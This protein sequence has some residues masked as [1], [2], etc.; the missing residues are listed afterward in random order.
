MFGMEATVIAWG[1]QKGGIGKTTS[2][3]AMS[4]LLAKKG[5]RVLVIDFDPQGSQIQVLT[6]QNKAD[7]EGFNIMMA[8]E[9]NNPHEHIVELTKE[10][11]IIPSDR[12]LAN[13]EAWLNKN[14]EDEFEKTQVLKNL[15]TPLNLEYD[16]IMLDLPPSLDLLTTNGLAASNSTVALLQPAPLSF[17]GLNEYIDTVEGLKEFVNPELD[18]LGILL[19]LV[20]RG[21]NVDTQFID[22]AK[23]LYSDLVFKP[24]VYRRTRLK[25]YAAIG[26]KE[27]SF[28]D[29]SALRPY[30]DLVKELI[31]RVG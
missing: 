26:M 28:I 24:I 1:G 18:V 27:D 25:Q 21:Q 30:K 15:I 7:F 20:D 17:D 29:R 6:G 4:F 5:Y 22:L 16:F 12:Y 23:D 11:H 9:E 3:A 8:I 14:V 10:L 19:T 13:F 2:C 31:Q